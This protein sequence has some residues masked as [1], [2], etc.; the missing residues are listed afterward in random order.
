MQLCVTPYLVTHRTPGTRHHESGWYQCSSSLD[1]RPGAGLPVAMGPAISGCIY[2]RVFPWSVQYST[3]QY[4][5]WSAQ[6]TQLQCVAWLRWWPWCLWQLGESRPSQ[7]SPVPAAVFHPTHIHTAAHSVCCIHSKSAT[8]FR[9]MFTKMHW[10]RAPTM[11]KSLGRF[12]LKDI[13]YPVIDWLC[14]NFFQC[15]FGIVS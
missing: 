8:K 4:S 9:E 5:T 7:S 11:A 10:L 1:P 13:F 6:S 2:L 3:V 14:W 15:P 12:T